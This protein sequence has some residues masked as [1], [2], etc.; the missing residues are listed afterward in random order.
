MQTNL[1]WA[2]REYCSLENCLVGTTPTGSDITSTIVG[3]YQGK[4]Y[5]V[6]YRIITNQQWETVGF[7][8]NSR[9]SDRTESI[10]FE[11]DGQGNWKSNGRRLEQFK[12]CLDLDIPLTP[13]TNTLPIRRLRLS[14]RESK[15]I[16]VI[17][18]DLL[19]N[20]IRAVRQ[21]YTCLSEREYHYENVPN[22]FEAVIQVDES[23]FVIDYPALF[24]RKASIVT[25]YH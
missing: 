10:K 9:H 11:G 6:E 22:D 24:V 21:R 1:L 15:E 17:Y 20:Q 18:C 25:H 13:F 3:C 19:E 2:G 5:K 8:I 7:E 16:D 12:G 23:G 4:V 14:P